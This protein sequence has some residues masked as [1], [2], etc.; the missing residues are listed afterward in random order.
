[1]LLRQTVRDLFVRAVELRTHSVCPRRPRTRLSGR[2][3]SQVTLES[4]E[5]RLLLT[6]AALPPFALDAGREATLVETET[7]GLESLRF[8]DALASIGDWDGDGVPDLAA[9][10]RVDGGADSA[11]VLL[12]LNS[13]GSVKDTIEI[14]DSDAGADSFGFGDAIALIG[15]LD[16]DGVDDLAIGDPFD[17]AE[18]Y[19]SVY[20]LLMN[21]D[22][23]VKGFDKDR[24]RC[25]RRADIAGL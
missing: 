13:D 11:V 9:G 3:L 1:M 20:V 25:W 12:L 19:G 23:S 10:G 4:L 14:L 7:A 5:P 24:Q 22:G 2:S 21:A 18:S 15:D 8:S 6:E 17:G 16:G